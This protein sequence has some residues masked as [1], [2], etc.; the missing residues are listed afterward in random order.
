MSGRS[1]L[2]VASQDN[3]VKGKPKFSRSGL[4]PVSWFPKEQTLPPLVFVTLVEL[5]LLVL[6]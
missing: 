3:V 4:N 1:L 2:G 6:V 5:V